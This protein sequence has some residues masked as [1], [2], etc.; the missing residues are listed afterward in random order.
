MLLSLNNILSE[1][2]GKGNISI[3]MNNFILL[4]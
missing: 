2:K 3:K 1:F 4:T